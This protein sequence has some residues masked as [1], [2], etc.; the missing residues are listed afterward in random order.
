MDTD[1]TRLISVDDAEYL[2]SSL[3]P[4]RRSRTPTRRVPYSKSPSP[5]LVSSPAS[6]SPPVVR[7]GCSNPP[8]LQQSTTQTAGSSDPSCQRPSAAQANSSSGSD[9]RSTVTQPTPDSFS[10]QSPN[11]PNDSGMRTRSQKQTA[12]VS[13]PSAGEPSAMEASIPKPDGENGRPGRGGYSLKTVLGWDPKEYKKAQEH[14]RG[15][16]ENML[17]KNVHTSF[18]SQP[19][20]VLN[21]LR[22]KMVEKFPQLRQYEDNWATDDFIRGALKYR[23]LQLKNRKLRMQAAQGQAIINMQQDSAP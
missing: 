1:Y 18:T 7:T 3:G 23:Q 11:Q 14:I 5:A 9:Q 21:P 20:E 10:K 6:A 19:P 12:T 13:V 17:P 22:K 4:A 15:L 16:V 8:C 2:P